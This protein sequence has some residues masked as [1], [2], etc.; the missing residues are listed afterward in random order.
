MEKGIY[1][2]K[3]VVWRNYIEGNDHVSAGLFHW[4][5]DRIWYGITAPKNIQDHYIW[6]SNTYTFHSF[7][8]ISIQKCYSSY[9]SPLFHILY[10]KR[11][12]SV[13]T[14]CSKKFFKSVWVF[15]Y[16]IPHFVNTYW[17]KSVGEPHFGMKIDEEILLIFHNVAF[18]SEK[19]WLH[20]FQA[21]LC[22]CFHIFA[23]D[24]RT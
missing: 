7:L 5:T 16:D 12:P 19:D 8:Y 17:V 21:L 24:Q 20:L 6:N 11:H 14:V 1:I 4:W 18:E 13:A 2:K 15:C 9:P 22:T 10:K 3:D 23:G